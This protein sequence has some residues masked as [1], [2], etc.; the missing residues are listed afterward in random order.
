VFVVLQKVICKLSQSGHNPTLYNLATENARMCQQWFTIGGL[1]LELLGFLL[2]AFEWRHVLWR[3]HERRIYELEHDYERSRSEHQGKE[4]IDPR[5]ADYTMWREFQKLFLKEWRF[6]RT[7]FY[8][9]VMLVVVG[10]LSQ[11]TGSLPYAMS[12]WGFKSC[13]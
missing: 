5:R 7:I 1:I 3:E 8:C 13:S 9:G 2:I 10:F 4:Y 6:R 11:T 12:V